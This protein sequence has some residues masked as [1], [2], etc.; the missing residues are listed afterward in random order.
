M[1][2]Q[3]GGGIQIMCGI[4]CSNVIVAAYLSRTV[5]RYAVRE[6]CL[7]VNLYIA[8]TGLEKR[9][10][11]SERAQDLTAELFSAVLRA[12]QATVPN[13]PAK[14]YAGPQCASYI[15]LYTKGA[16]GRHTFF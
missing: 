12:R 1:A 14:R 7:Y 15:N 8:G 6:A 10:A 9:Y 5:E 11:G 2:H 13:S 4:I 16:F 3:H